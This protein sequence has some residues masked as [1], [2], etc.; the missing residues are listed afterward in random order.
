MAPLARNRAPV[1]S[2]ALPTFAM[3]TD[4]SDSGSDLIKLN[5]NHIAIIPRGINVA[6]TGLQPINCNISPNKAS[7]MN[8]PSLAPIIKNPKALPLSSGLNEAAIIAFAL[9]I[10]MAEPKPATAL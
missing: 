7:P 2:I 1:Q 10:I 9:P 8:V 4:L 6:K 3:F 5:A